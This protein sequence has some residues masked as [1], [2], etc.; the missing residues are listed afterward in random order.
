M[1]DNMKLACDQQAMFGFYLMLMDIVAN[2][3]TAYEKAVS[4]QATF[5]LGYIGE[6]TA[7]VDL[8]LQ[9]LPLHIYRL[10][11]LYSKLMEFIYVTADSILK[12]DIKM[13]E[14]MEG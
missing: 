13:K 10:E 14:N 6:A 2:L 9:S 7:E 4:A 3:N 1:G 5:A 12:N 11:I 8:F